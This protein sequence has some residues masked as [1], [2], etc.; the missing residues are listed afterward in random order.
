MTS[1]SPCSC[2]FQFGGDRNGFRQRWNS[3]IDKNDRYLNDIT[4]NPL[5][6]ALGSIEFRQHTPVIGILTKQPFR[7][8]Q[9][10]FIGLKGVWI[11][12]LHIH[13]W[14]DRVM[15][16]LTTVVLFDNTVTPIKFFWYHC[17]SEVWVLIVAVQGN[18]C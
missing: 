5:I 2:P 8:R 7:H 1:K 13:Q 4:G 17:L 11:R 14:P 6:E 9:H 15:I 16:H 12:F 18:S 3:L 10:G